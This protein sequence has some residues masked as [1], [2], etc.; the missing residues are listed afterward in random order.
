MAGQFL[1]L[2]VVLDKLVYSPVGKVL[3]DRDAQL[4]SKLEAVKD[5]SSDL[6]KF[7]V[8][9]TDAAASSAGLRRRH[10]RRRVR[11]R[12]ARPLRETAVCAPCACDAYACA[13]PYARRPLAVLTR[14]PRS[15]EEADS[16][17]A[18]ARNEAS[19]VIA[20][21]KAKA[22]GESNVKIAEAKAKLDKELKSATASLEQQRQSSLASID[23]EVAKLS[24]F[25]VNKLVP[26]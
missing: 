25:I 7:T 13:T 4:R 2:M 20:K 24:D 26:V 12:R 16:I 17:I 3:D 5:N 21:A 14:R 9:H 15:Q 18:A 8:R 19:A 22:D 6:L 1:V 11:S 10:S 23:A